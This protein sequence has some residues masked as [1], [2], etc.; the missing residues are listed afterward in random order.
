MKGMRMN[1][2]R[3]S[4]VERYTVLGAGVH[5]EIKYRL[6]VITGE[7]VRRAGDHAEVSWTSDTREGVV[8]GLVDLFRT[9]FVFEIKSSEYFISTGQFI[10]Q[11]VRRRGTVRRLVR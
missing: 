3:C 11:T 8:P 4:N 9:T 2:N 1:C 6:R 7:G 5:P 10:G